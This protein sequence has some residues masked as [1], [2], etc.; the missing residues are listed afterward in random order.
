MLRKE[1]VGDPHVRNIQPERQKQNTDNQQGG[2]KL[3]MRGKLKSN[4]NHHTG[5]PKNKLIIT[6]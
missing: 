4:N 1:V 2:P 3:G 6:W 5:K